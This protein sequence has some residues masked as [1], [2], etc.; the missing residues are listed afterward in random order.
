MDE[1]ERRAFVTSVIEGHKEALDCLSILKK[2]NLPDAW[3]GGGFVRNPVWDRLHG[4]E[5]FTPLN[6]VDVLF[7]DSDDLSKDTEGLIQANL[8]RELPEAAWSVK[9]QARMH[10]HNGDAPY[11]NTE[12]AV[13]R[14]V[15]TATAVAV[16]LDENDKLELCAPHGLEDLTSLVLCPTLA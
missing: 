1:E 6:D 8:S 7:F 14:W 3:I 4:Y 15:E 9:N 11:E 16:R 10:L 12:Q 5:I 2:L 13:A